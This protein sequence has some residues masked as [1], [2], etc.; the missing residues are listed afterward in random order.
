[1][2]RT[3]TLVL[4]LS[5]CAVF[6]ASTDLGA[7]TPSG[8]TAYIPSAPNGGL[9]IVYMTDDFSAGACVNG[10]ATSPSYGWVAADDFVLADDTDL[11]KLTCWAINNPAPSG[12]YMRFWEDTGGSGPGSELANA[13]ATAVQTSTGVYL[14]GYLCYKYE[15][16]FD[17]SYS[18]DAGHYWWAFGMSSGFVYMLCEAH[19]YD[20]MV[21]FD[22]GGGGAGPWYS[23]QYM[24][25]EAYDFFQTV[26][27]DTGPPDLDPPYVT[28]MDPDDGQADVPTDSTIVFHCVDDLHPIDTTT[29]DF[30]VLD[31]TLSGDRFESTGA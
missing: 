5:V 30:T 9:D 4:V 26:E 25:G 17:P 28:G 8:A 11:T 29:I 1:M 16:T 10:V 22:Y 23:S 7:I 19:A 27:G 12:F 6:A 14:W 15:I 21:Y 24:W 20:Y 31:S 2:M 3:L 13:P 18:M